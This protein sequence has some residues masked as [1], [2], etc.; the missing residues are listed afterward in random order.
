VT[1]ERIGELLRAGEDIRV[2]DRTSGE[3]LTAVTMSQVLLETERRRHGAVPDSMLQ[4]L[5]KGP[6]AILGAVRQSFSAGQDV[7]Q[8]AEERVASVQEQVFDEALAR[9]LHG[10][11]L[12]TQKDLQRLERKVSE[13]SSRLDALSGSVEELQKLASREMR[14]SGR[15]GGPR[16]N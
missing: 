15:G 5:V 11:R 14:R 4:Q 16:S 12:P 7:I 3:D 1:L 2:V 13:L 10:L 8:R 9:T 6:E